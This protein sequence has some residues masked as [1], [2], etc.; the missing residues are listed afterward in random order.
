M[1]IY[2]SKAAINMFLFACAW[3]IMGYAAWLAFAIFKVQYWIDI[4]YIWDK[5]LHTLFIAA[6]CLIPIHSRPELWSV[7]I[8]SCL[9]IIWEIVS[10]A[11]DISINDQMIVG[12]F[13]LL[14]A[15]GAAT[16]FLKD[17]VSRW[18]QKY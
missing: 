17:L 7:F 15:T 8:F 18:S 12:I 10:I 13:F 4:Y 11:G 5:S 6:G 2:V 3:F 16:Y 9:I 1:M 14:L